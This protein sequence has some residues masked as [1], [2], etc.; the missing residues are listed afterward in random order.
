MT[1]QATVIEMQHWQNGMRMWLR[2]ALRISMEVTGRSG[3]RVCRDAIIDMAQTARKETPKA[4][5]NRPVEVETERG[6]GKYVTIYRQR[7]PPYRR[8]EWMYSPTLLPADIAK[9]NPGGKTWA[10]AKRIRKA[11]LSGQSWF[12]P[13]RGIGK[14]QATGDHPPIPGATSLYTIRQANNCGYIEANRLSWITAIMPAGWEQR[15]QVS[16]EN[17]M[18]ANAIRQVGAEWQ[19]ALARDNHGS[20]PSKET[21]DAFFTPIQE[22]A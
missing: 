11:G 1:T 22:A 20:M 15:C 2:D 10:D 4:P 12:W 19:P 16:A 6:L 9:Y 14:E 13:L 21:L 8:Y 3:A 17:R 18:M 7:Q 5:A